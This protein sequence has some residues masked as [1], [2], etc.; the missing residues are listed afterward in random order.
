MSYRHRVRIEARTQ[1]RSS[2][3]ALIEA[4]LPLVDRV[5]ADI[6]A[7]SGRELFAAMEKHPEVTTAIRIRWMPTEVRPDMRIVHDDD[8]GRVYQIVAVLPDSTLR[9]DIRLICSTGV[10]QGE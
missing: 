10:N 4:W 7:L 9:H 5:P 1:S 3:G 6:E 2:T 8:G